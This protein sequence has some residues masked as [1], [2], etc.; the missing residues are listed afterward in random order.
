MRWLLPL[1]LWL[2]PTPAADLPTPAANAA[3]YSAAQ[4]INV[5]MIGNSYTAGTWRHFSDFATADPN[6]TLTLQLA[7]RGG[8]TTL[9]HYQNRQ[10]MAYQS[11]SYSLLDLLAQETW[12]YVVIQEQSTRPSQAYLGHTIERNQFERG[13]LNLDTVIK[14]E[15]PLAE[16]IYFQTWPR[17]YGNSYLTSYF[18]NEPK[19]MHKATATAYAEAALATGADT[20]HVGTAWNYSMYQN[21]GLT[22]HSGDGSH[23]GA[24]GGYLAGA[25]FYAYLYD[26]TPVGNTY[27]GGLPQADVDWLQALAEGAW[28]L[29][30]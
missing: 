30:D 7:T 28:Q 5:L 26:Q 29:L 24:A 8:W 9:D 2:L 16:V 20:V 21:A 23:A 1:L 22:L 18:S 11:G 15:A 6:T 12:D 19:L 17:N 10:S 27:S 25:M 14:R 4:H 3:P 13:M